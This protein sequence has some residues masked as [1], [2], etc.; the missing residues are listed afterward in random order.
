MENAGRSAAEHILKKFEGPW[1]VVAGKGN[2]GGDALVVARHLLL[3]GE[4]DITVLFIPGKTGRS[5][6]PA[7]LGL[8]KRRM[9]GCPISG[10]KKHCSTN[11]ERCKYHHRWNIWNRASGT[12]PWRCRRTD[13]SCQ[14]IGEKSRE[15]G[16]SQWTGG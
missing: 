1:V 6:C 14:S 2:N 8:E 15:F 11:T 9:Q 5:P 3:R 4:K 12:C 10:R 16:C 13:R 7:P